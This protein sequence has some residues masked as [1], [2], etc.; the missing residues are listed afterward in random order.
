MLLIRILLF[1][2]AVLYDAITRFRNRLYDLKIKP[3]VKFELPVIC[4]GNLSVGGTGKTPVI[5]YLI[6]LL[7]KE[8]KTVVLSRGYKRK[9]KGFRMA[10][11]SDTAATL[12]DEPFQ[13]Y[14]KYHDRIT[15]AVGEDRV[16]AIPTIV[17]QKENV[18]VILMDDGFQHRR[19]TPGFS[20]LLTDYSN[21]FYT[22]FLLPSGRL[23]EARSNANRADAIVV[24]KCPTNVDAEDMNKISVA[25]KRYTQKPIFFSSLL[26][27]NIV[28]FGN[29]MATVTKTV[30]LVTG[31]ANS[32]ALVSFVESNYMLKD[33]WNYADHYDYKEQD[34]T[35]MEDF[36]ERNPTAMILTT[37]KDMVKLSS[38]M[39]K[40][41]VSKLPFYY[42]PIEVQ[43][44]KDGKEFDELV[45][46][47][48]LR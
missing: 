34:L 47:S 15:V 42:L 20:I 19:V 44:L 31:I 13:L 45:L 46:Q 33:H 30:L 10:D 18:E 26:Y 27:G 48:I 16:M 38:P 28:S 5:E 39:F 2:F 8:Y 6:R 4:V 11:Q 29:P 9:T 35:K 7:S 23:R 3:S 22:D 21:P 17:Q 1:P 43:F 12:G 14:N 32:K 36:I 25:V 37:E 40:H 41:R 24:T